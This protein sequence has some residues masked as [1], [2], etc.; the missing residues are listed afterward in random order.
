VESILASGN[1]KVV[2][3]RA[4]HVTEHAAPIARFVTAVVTDGIQTAELV[5]SGIQLACV[6]IKSIEEWIGDFQGVQKEAKKLPVEIAECALIVVVDMAPLVKPATEGLFRDVAQKFM[7]LVLRI[8]A[9]CKKW[10]E[11]G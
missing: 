6:A 11:K 7:D 3:D 8:Y 1:T 4:K 9:L 5:V 2:L 10:D